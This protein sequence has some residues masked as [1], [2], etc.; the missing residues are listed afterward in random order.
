VR[1]FDV[2]LMPVGEER[3]ERAVEMPSGLGTV[4]C[5]VPVAPTSGSW[6][7]CPPVVAQGSV[8]AP[9]PDVV[10]ATGAVR[11]A[12]QL[13][14]LLWPLS[15]SAALLWGPAWPSEPIGTS[16]PPGAVSEA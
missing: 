3:V 12:I 5:H 15:A 8:E 2:Q 13:W 9:E 6:M 16:G 10:V 14:V 1:S 7:I 11:P 4:F